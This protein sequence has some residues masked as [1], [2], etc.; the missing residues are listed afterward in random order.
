[1]PDFFEGSLHAVSVRDRDHNEQPA[2]LK[3]WY[4]IQF[5]TLSCRGAWEFA[6]P[7]HGWPQ[8]LANAGGI[9]II[10]AVGLGWNYFLL[11]TRQNAAPNDEL[12]RFF[13]GKS[14]GADVD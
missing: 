2:D 7:A 12:S 1:M 3:P 8:P 6:F 9:G 10:S 11:L 5:L 4:H 14:V 13:E